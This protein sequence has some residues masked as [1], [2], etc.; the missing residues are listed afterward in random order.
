[1]V[2]HYIPGDLVVRKEVSSHS[3]EAYIL[4]SPGNKRLANKHIKESLQIVAQCSEGKHSGLLWG[5]GVKR[6]VRLPKG[7]KEGL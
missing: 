6:G 2:R 1:M 7:V 3:P 4:S 5:R